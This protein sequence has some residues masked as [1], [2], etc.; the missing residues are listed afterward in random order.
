[1]AFD[2]IQEQ[3]NGWDG[4]LSLGVSE[5]ANTP[6]RWLTERPDLPSDRLPG[7]YRLGEEPSTATLNRRQRRARRLFIRARVRIG[8]PKARDE[9]LFDR[10]AAFK[11][12]TSRVSMYMDPVWRAELFR[13][14]DFWLK[15]ETWPDDASLPTEASYST[16]L[17]LVAHLR[18]LKRPSF[19]VGPTGNL[20]ATWRDDDARLFVDFQEEDEVRWAASQVVDKRREAIAGQCPIPRIVANLHAYRPDRWFAGP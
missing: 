7:V 11:I 5:A 6:I 17:K 4:I 16:F 9:Q 15:P 1:M 14:L 19:G 2:A 20:V 8:P 18:P 3:Q 10:L 12:L 13:Q